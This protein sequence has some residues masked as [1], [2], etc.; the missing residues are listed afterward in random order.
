MPTSV[1][2]LRSGDR[3]VFEAV[4]DVIAVTD[5]L[6]PA[7]V[8]TMVTRVLIGMSRP[9]QP[10]A[11]VALLSRVPEPAVAT[12][13]SPTAGAPELVVTHPLRQATRLALSMF[14]HDMC[15]SSN[16]QAMVWLLNLE[17]E[18]APAEWRVGT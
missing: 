13:D 11:S 8:A 4:A 2:P 14:H 6:A 1:Q 9:K 18:T 10:R 5:A 17:R 15:G 7:R 12:T 3:T 16:A